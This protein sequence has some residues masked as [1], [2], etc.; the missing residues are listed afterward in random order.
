[1]NLTTLT[2]A[3]PL[4]APFWGDFTFVPT[5][6]SGSIYYRVTNDSLTLDLMV[7]RIEEINS[8]IGLY[9]PTLAVIVTWYNS[10]V[11][12]FNDIVVCGS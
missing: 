12:G 6:N 3:F 1:M 7:E 5:M 2:L 8:D 9:R 10:V 11:F 4:I